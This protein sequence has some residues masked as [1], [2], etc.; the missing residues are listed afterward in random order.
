LSYKGGFQ[1]QEQVERIERKKIENTQKMKRRVSGFFQ[2]LKFDME[3]KSNEKKKNEESHNMIINIKKNFEWEEI[4]RK[5]DISFFKKESLNFLESF[6]LEN[7]NFKNAF[8]KKF[9]DN[10]G[11]EF[12]G[13]L[14]CIPIIVGK[15]HD[16]TLR[17][18]FDMSLLESEESI[19]EANQNK[20]E[21]PSKLKKV[22]RSRSCM[23]LM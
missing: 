23:L 7:Y 20:E 15:Y 17:N 9:V 10:M 13:S 21:S 3:Q 6:F 12:L 8:N 4:E 19:K 14:F 5:I 18:F 11:K 1:G 2:K 16:A 22:V